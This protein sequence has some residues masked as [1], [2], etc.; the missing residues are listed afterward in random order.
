[1]RRL[2]ATIGMLILLLPSSAA[3]KA[4][5]WSGVREYPGDMF[6]SLREELRPEGILTLLTAGAGASIAR[7]GKTAHFDDFSAADTLPRNR[8]LGKAA[9]D[10]GAVV[11]YPGYLLTAMAATYVA[12]GFFDAEQAREIGL[13]GFEALSLA[14]IQTLTLKFSVRRIRPD[15]TDLNAFPSGHASASFALAA[16]AASKWGWRAGVPAFLTAGFVG[17]T[18]L[19]SNKHYLSDVL[20]GAGLGIASGRAVFKVRRR[21]HP[22]RYAVA[23]FVFPG[24]GGVRVI[25]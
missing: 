2:R 15:S 25:F 8:P 18:R 23:P 11:G 5:V 6:H 14:G 12:G 22:D 9:T 19:E 21:A 16:T 7:Y 24:G 1:M 4:G 13:L 10:A 3:G 20:F 17:Y